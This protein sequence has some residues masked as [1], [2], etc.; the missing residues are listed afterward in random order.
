MQE[1]DLFE[2][3]ESIGPELKTILD[4]YEEASIDGFSYQ[5]LAAMLCEVE[6]VG[7]TFEYGLD[8]IPYNLKPI[9][10]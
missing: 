7:Y 4:K 2:A 10:L 1:I 8:A 5:E 6:A 3:Y 9:K